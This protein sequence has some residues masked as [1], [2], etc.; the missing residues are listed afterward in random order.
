MCHR[1]QYDSWKAGPHAAKGLDCEGCHGAGADYAKVMRDRAKA[2]AA[3]LLIPTVATCQRCHPKADA[4]LLP[5]AHAH[6][7]R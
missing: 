4:S 6:K 1:L 2:V 3:G 5:K 7:A